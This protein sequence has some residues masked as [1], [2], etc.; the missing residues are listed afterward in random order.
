MKAFSHERCGGKRAGLRVFP[1]FEPFSQGG[2][3][4]RVQQLTGADCGSRLHSRMKIF[5]HF[6]HGVC[7][8]K[9]TGAH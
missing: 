3:A 4:V 7:N 5:R 6:C 1:A 9:S 8:W 2:K